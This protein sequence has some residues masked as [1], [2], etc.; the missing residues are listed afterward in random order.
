[1]NERQR[2][3]ASYLLQA[4]GYSSQKQ[5]ME[6]LPVYTNAREIRRD[7]RELNNGEFSYIIVSGNKGYAIASEEK[8]RAF[9]EKK[10]KTALRM[11][12]LYE[13]LKH[14]FQNDG[15]TKINNADNIIQ[16]HTV[17]DK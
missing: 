8:A 14:K 9:L 16:V 1:M 5:I 17:C 12:S 10:H 11:L 15:Q 4:E 7:V 2:L 13:S 3:L 6:D